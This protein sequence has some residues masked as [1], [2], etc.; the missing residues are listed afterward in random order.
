MSRLLYLKAVLLVFLSLFICSNSFAQSATIHFRVNM[1]HYISEN[2]FDETSETIDI[3]GTFNNWGGTRMDLTKGQTDSVYSRTISGFSVGQAIEFKFRINGAWNDREEFVGAGNNRKWTVSTTQ[4]TISVWYNDL[5]PASGPPIANFSVVNTTLFEGQQVAIINDSDGIIDSYYWEFEGASPSTSTEKQP[6][7]MYPDSGVYS[8]KLIVSNN[9]GQADTLE[10]IDYITVSPRPLQTS[11]W[12]NNRVFYEIFVRSFYDSNGDGVGDIN[13]IIEKLDYLNDGDPNTTTDLG[14]GGIWLMPIHPSPSY[15]GYDVT[16]YRGVH[17]QY[18]TLDDFKRLVSEAH[19]R[20]IAVIIDYVMNHSSSQHEWFQQSANN[21]STYRDYYVWSQTNPGFTGPWGQTVWINRNGSYYYA[22]FWDGMPDINYNNEAV[23]DSI[24]NSASFWINET[25][26]DGFRLDA[27][28]YIFEDGSKTED[29]PATHE[30]FGEF[31]AHIKNDNPNVFTVGEAWTST[32]KV[33]DYVVPDRIDYCF[34]FDVAGAIISSI[35]SAN[36][37]AA[38]SAISKAYNSYPNQQMGLFLTN[39]DMTRVQ[40][41]FGSSITKNKVAA[42]IYL[43]LPGIPYIY[44]GEELGMTGNK[45]SG[46]ENVRTPMHWNNNS[47]AGFTTGN[48]WRSVNSE[49]NSKNVALLSTDE[50]SILSH[51]RKLVQLRNRTPELQTGN[52][53]FFPSS[54]KR[55]L[56]YSRSKMA[57]NFDS[58]LIVVTNLSNQTL[59]NVVFTPVGLVDHTVSYLMKDVLTEREITFSSESSGGNVIPEL[60]PYET[61][62]LRVVAHTLS[63]ETQPFR[64]SFELEPVYPNPFNPTTTARFNL[65]QNGLIELSVF[66]TIGRKVKSILNEYRPAGNYTVSVDLQEYSSGVYFLQL[67]QA[68][69]V[70]IQKMSLIK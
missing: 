27:V 10:K 68:E 51:Y 12:W 30:F 59:T 41:E 63:N 29:V 53:T 61:L 21:N 33:I 13:G 39:H 1:S 26:V 69:N 67:Q 34:E 5:E 15:H 22:L 7:V 37:G 46:D 70:E 43:T 25:G 19:K 38:S 42:S 66:D 55:I 47:N 62:L 49:Y 6:L 14:I 58:T 8:I 60:Q 4:D 31:S 48:P 65:A 32:D 35:N 3:A 44:Y 52:L 11:R 24:F 23:K 64:P 9:S 56:M 17:P 2:L 50:N 54:E 20:G 18:G 57:E 45:S 28:K 40:N 36:N 16:N